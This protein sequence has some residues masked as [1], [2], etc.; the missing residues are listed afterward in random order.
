[1]IIILL[2]IGCVIFKEAFTFEN[3]IIFPHQTITSW[4]SV[5]LSLTKDTIKDYLIIFLQTTQHTTPGDIVLY[6][7]QNISTIT[8]YVYKNFSKIECNSKGEY[9]NYDWKFSSGDYA[10][11]ETT[12]PNY[13]LN[14]P[15]Y[16]LISLTNLVFEGSIMIFNELDVNP[17]KPN[18][19]INIRHLYS[20]RQLQFSYNNTDNKEYI[21]FAFIS[22]NLL[23]YVT[24]SGF[25]S[26]HNSKGKELQKWELVTERKYIYCHNQTSSENDDNYY[27]IILK[28]TNMERTN[29]IKFNM[30]IKVDTMI[31]I[32]YKLEHNNSL[33]FAIIPNMNYYFYINIKD[34][35]INEENSIELWINEKTLR[36]ELSSNLII[37]NNFLECEESNLKYNYPTKQ[38]F[39]NY[40]K[41][42]KGEKDINYT[43]IPFRKENINHN[44]FI[45]AINLNVTNP[46]SMHN[47]HI[48]ISPRVKYFHLTTDHFN[49]ST[50]IFETEFFPISNQIT[51]FLKITYDKKLLEKSQYLSFYITQPRI[52]SIILGPM[53]LE[54]KLPNTLYR[55]S[56]FQV[57]DKNHHTINNTITFGFLGSLNHTTVQI[58]LIKNSLIYFEHNQR[59]IS[60]SFNLELINCKKTL[61]YIESLDDYTKNKVTLLYDTLYGNYSIDYYNKITSPLIINPNSRGLTI[62]NKRYFSFESDNYNVLK[63]NCISPT[64]IKTTFIHNEITTMREVTINDGDTQFLQ[65]AS[66]SCYSFILNTTKVG[67]FYNVNIQKYS[68]SSLIISTNDLNYTLNN[69]TNEIQLTYQ[70][71]FTFKLPFLEICSEEEGN[72]F[73]KIEMASEELMNKII[74]GNSEIQ[75]QKNKVF[76][77]LR[78]DIIYD[79]L[80]I[81]MYSKR[82]VDNILMKYS[83]DKYD[84]T[85][86]KVVLPLNE[87]QFQKE[88][89]LYFSNPYNKYNVNLGINKSFIYSMAILNQNESDYN[90]FINIKY[91]TIN[92][93]NTSIGGNI[94]TYG[95]KYRMDSIKEQKDMF[96]FYF[97]D[98]EYKFN[99]NVNHS[100]QF[101]LSYG[102]D[103]I[104]ETTDNFKSDYF[105][106]FDNV[107]N[108]AIFE[109]LNKG[110][111]NDNNKNK[112]YVN[113]FYINKDDLNKYHLVN[114]YIINSTYDKGI[115]YLEWFPLFNNSN[116]VLYEI[117]LIPMNS[118]ISINDISYL[119]QINASF[120]IHNISNATFE[121]EPMNY[122]VNII[123]KCKD[124]IFPFESIYQGID[125]Y[126]LNQRYE[127]FITGIKIV[128]IVTLLMLIIGIYIFKKRRSMKYKK[129]SEEKNKDD[130]QLLEKSREQE[131]GIFKS[132][133]NEIEEGTINISLSK[134]SMSISKENDL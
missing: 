94:L 96:I 61:Y 101:V 118:N 115:M 28:I 103:E 106:V 84:N 16:F 25:L 132:F 87:F 62:S 73:I 31:E 24:Y 51:S 63:I 38:I 126:I 22:D 68:E 134:S 53:L 20:Q 35:A 117:Y 21:V 32:P 109:I 122:K 1:M 112:I 52:S 123:A 67:L 79:Y 14:S 12:D 77:R 56:K 19:P 97:S 10:R 76:H 46:K 130:Q 2:Y 110:N 3:I 99:N 80:E 104:V 27:F 8:I 15:Y 45:I 114:N 55:W 127:I 59:K 4:E 43:I 60:Q 26:I 41:P 78:N 102:N 133:G 116:N 71:M 5:S 9:L 86:T 48:N 70:R 66:T 17:L 83:F 131:E 82:Q 34:Y 30:I 100:A 69:E 119:T 65:L 40:T 44:F 128:I 74:E 88:T 90:V 18:Q 85:E 111:T 37:Y 89:V 11:I 50:N 13:K 124:T 49:S 92:A 91:I 7:N 72:V 113:Y 36:Y 129:V 105:Y 93:Q 108:G 75:F 120:I 23:F 33:K 29:V 47:F 57:I 125:I 42:K 58:A 64:N 121:V 81:T 107:Y 54:T 98:C 95:T 6:S 39:S